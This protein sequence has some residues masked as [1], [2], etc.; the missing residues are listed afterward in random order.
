MIVLKTTTA[1]SLC[2]CLSA[3]LA[4][5]EPGQLPIQRSDQLTLSLLLDN[6]LE[7]YPVYEEL[8]ARLEEAAKYDN[9][10]SSLLSNSMGVNGRY[11]TGQIGNNAPI[12]IGWIGPN[13]GHADHSP[14]V[15][16]TLQ[17]HAVI[18]HI[19]AV[20]DGENN[21]RVVGQAKRIE[22]GQDAA[23]LVIDHGDHAIGQGGDLAGF[24]FVVDYQYPP[25]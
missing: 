24:A 9:K 22:P 25:L 15:H 8:P 20:V 16:R 10:A 7:K 18:A 13:E 14:R 12:R 2:L 4:Q 17:H 6:V 5:T 3:A 1:V 23:D 19:I 21:D 11:Q